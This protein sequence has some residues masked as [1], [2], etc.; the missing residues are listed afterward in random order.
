[1]QG[2][3]DRGVVFMCFGAQMKRLCYKRLY[4]VFYNIF[5]AYACPSETLA[6]G[7]ATA[8]DKIPK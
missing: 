6:R 5:I 1:M 2:F 7:F 3:M 4:T 8:D